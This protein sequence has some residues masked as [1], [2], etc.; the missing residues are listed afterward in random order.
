MVSIVCVNHEPITVHTWE[1][2]HFLRK[3][4]SCDITWSSTILYYLNYIWD[5]GTIE[6]E[7][8]FI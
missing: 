6:C 3:D 5:S 7:I 1:V 2:S 4:D 8:G